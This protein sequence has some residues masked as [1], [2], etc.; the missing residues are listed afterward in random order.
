[1]SQKKKRSLIKTGKQPPYG[2]GTMTKVFETI[3][4]NI[5]EVADFIE[6]N[7]LSFVCNDNMQVEAPEEDFQKLIEQFPELDYVEA[8]K[9]PR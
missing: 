5:Q 9:E 4:L 3:N 7:G 1:L 2:A 6:Q 8:E